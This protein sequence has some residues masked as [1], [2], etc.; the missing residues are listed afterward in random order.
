MWSNVSKK[1]GQ[2]TDTKRDV[3]VPVVHFFHFSPHDECFPKEYLLWLSNLM[4]K[5]D[6]FGSVGHATCTIP[7]GQF[8]FQA[9]CA[10]EVSCGL[11]Q[12]GIRQGWCCQRG[13]HIF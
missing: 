7:L 8:H 11:S 3:V 4:C 13:G 6:V 5:D 9:G 1:L 10:S 2:Y 12:W